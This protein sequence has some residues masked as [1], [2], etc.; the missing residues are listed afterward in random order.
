M[1]IGRDKNL[2]HF[3]QGSETAD[4]DVEA[5][6][7][8]S[9]PLC[10]AETDGLRSEIRRAREI[11]AERDAAVCDRD[12][13]LAD[14]ERSGVQ[15]DAAI[16][17]RVCE[18]VENI[19]ARLRSADELLWSARRR[20]C[21]RASR[22]SRPRSSCRALRCRGGSSAWKREEL[23]R[24]AD[25]LAAELQSAQSSYAALVATVGPM[26]FELA[27]LRDQVYAKTYSFRSVCL[28]RLRF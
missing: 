6:T 19:S 28:W 25:S 11:V 7:S 21:R 1:E 18:L 24:R 3:L 4:D 27:S 22:P 12:R 10:A 20:C 13:R 23:R 14:L 26:D 5:T 9:P 2:R 17:A 15:K 16:D 8:S